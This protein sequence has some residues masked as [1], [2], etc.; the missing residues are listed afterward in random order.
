VEWELGRKGLVKRWEELPPS[1][2]D[3][4]FSSGA[5]STARF[6]GRESPSTSGKLR[7]MYG[8]SHAAILE[9]T[10]VREG[11]EYGA[12]A[13]MGLEKCEAVWL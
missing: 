5:S 4:N 6:G 11:E 8:I 12:M 9:K 7:T 10:P 3:T 13:P 1:K 2:K